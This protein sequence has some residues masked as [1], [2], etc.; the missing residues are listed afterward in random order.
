ML[1]APACNLHAGSDLL[2]MRSD[3][4]VFGERLNE[5]CRVRD[6]TRSQLFRSIGFGGRRVISFERSGLRILD[7]YRVCQMADALDVSLDWLLGRSN[8]M[9]V[10]E[11]PELPEPEPPRK[12]KAAS[13]GSAA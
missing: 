8:V 2:H 10:M 9:S 13:K 11:M 4:L 7:L 3:F 1:R 5:A 12:K 6:I